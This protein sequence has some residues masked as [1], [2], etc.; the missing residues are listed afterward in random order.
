MQLLLNKS[1]Q[2]LTSSASRSCQENTAIHIYQPMISK[3]TCPCCS[4][5]LLRH[6]DLKGIYWRCSHCYQ[7][8]PVYQPS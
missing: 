3:H 5:T 6:I 7:E 2:G 4:Y 1:L 8:M